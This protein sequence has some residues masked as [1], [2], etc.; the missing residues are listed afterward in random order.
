MNKKQVSTTYLVAGILFCVCLITANILE[1]KLIQLG[2]IH[3]TAGVLVFPITYILNDCL[4]EVW[5]FSKA[6]FIIWMGFLMN[7][8]VV[9]IVQLAIILPSAPYYEHQ[10]AFSTT[11][12][13]TPRIAAASFTAFLIGSFLNAYV[14]SKMKISSKGKHFSLR[15]VA[16]TLV[17]ETADSLIFFPIAFYGSVPSE[18]LLFMILSQIAIKTSYEIIALPLTCR[19]VKKMKKWD[20]SDVYDHNT[21]YNILKLG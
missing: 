5:G 1:V 3:M 15:A 11:F 14:M 12:G 19:I 4:S 18:A 2:P 17:G 7:F 16:S 20:G 13:S 9:S 8:F 21:S 6:R 10:E